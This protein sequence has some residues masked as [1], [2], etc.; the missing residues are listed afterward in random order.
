MKMHFDPYGH[1]DYD[2][3]ETYPC[4][5]RVGWWHG[6]YNTTAVWSEVT[7]KRCL[8]QREKLQAW[9]DK[10][11]SAIYGGIACFIDDMTRGQ[12]EDEE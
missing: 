9:Y 4:G 3:V 10:T 7:C 1:Y 12:E 11:E 5:T 2:D 6:W 8:R